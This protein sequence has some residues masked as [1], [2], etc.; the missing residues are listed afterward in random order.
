MDYG[1]AFHIAKYDRVSPRPHTS[2]SFGTST[3]CGQSVN[4]V[5]PNGSSS[6]SQNFIGS[7]P[8]LEVLRK[9]IAQLLA[10]LS[11]AIALRKT[12]NFGNDPMKFCDDD[13]EPFG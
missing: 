8:K 11:I 12:S 4:P 5:I 7:F 13:D 3:A 1:L 9:A 10:S 6:S 2:C